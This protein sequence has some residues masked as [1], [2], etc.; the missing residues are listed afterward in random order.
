MGNQSGNRGEPD[1]D[2]ALDVTRTRPGGSE[3]A[4]GRA[5]DAP[6]LPLV[7]AR[8]Y[9]VKGEFARGGL[10]RILEAHDHRLGRKVALKQLLHASDDALARFAREALVTAR[11]QH[12][13]IV[14][15]Y[16]AGRFPTGQPFFAMKLV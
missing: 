8:H 13:A 3:E 2:P 10:G 7:D 14:P 1:G 12:P 6:E 11:L 15:V 5:P 9:S 16:E 4:P